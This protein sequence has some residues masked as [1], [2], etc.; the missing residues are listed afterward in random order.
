MKE[1]VLPVETI[2]HEIRSGLEDTTL[3][4]ATAGI[5]AASLSLQSDLRKS[6]ETA[7]V[8]GRCGGSIR[9]RL[10][11]LLAPL[12]RP[13]IEQLDLFHAATVSTLSKLAGLA[14]DHVA[15]I[16]KTVDLERRV[17]ALEAKEQMRSSAGN[18]AER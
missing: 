1:N 13:V 16:Q 8:L 9:G 10:C 15:A 5:A 18:G 6:A 3:S 17:Q 4:A 14:D 12:A 11:L 7:G 2:M